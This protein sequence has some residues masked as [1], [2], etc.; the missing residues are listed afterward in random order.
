MIL[1][2]CVVCNSNKLNSLEK[3]TPLCKIFVV[4]PLCFQGYEQVN[5]RYKTYEIVNRLLLVENKFMPE[6]HLRQPGFNYNACG[7]FNRKNKK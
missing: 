4:G 7:P 1:S 2:N 3:Q 5:T 6:M